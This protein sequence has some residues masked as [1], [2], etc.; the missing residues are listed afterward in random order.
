[1]QHLYEFTDFDVFKKAMIE[2]KKATSATA[3]A[4]DADEGCVELDEGFFEQMRGENHLDTASG[5]AKS[6]DFAEE[7]KGV[8]GTIYE[9]KF[10]GYPLKWTRCD[11]TF[12]DI[13]TQVFDDFFK[14]METI[15]KKRPEVMRFDILAKSADGVP[16]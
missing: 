9:K 14:N 10:E 6:T 4:N 8:S 7:S 5:W 1:M 13:S 16:H 15:Y 2:R 11:A 3:S 12:K